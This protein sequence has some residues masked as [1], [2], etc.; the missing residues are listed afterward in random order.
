MCKSHLPKVAWLEAPRAKGESELDFSLSD[1]SATEDARKIQTRSRKW[2]GA[3]GRTEH[4][5]RNSWRQRQNQFGKS[6]SNQT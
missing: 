6:G 1:S 2:L 5:P 3:L 4:Y